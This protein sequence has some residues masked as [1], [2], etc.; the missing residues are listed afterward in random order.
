MPNVSK[1]R[2]E[3][4]LHLVQLW[5]KED[6]Y[7]QIKAAADSVQEP[8]TNWCRRALFTSLRKWEVPMAP[9]AAFEPC[10][11]CGKRHDRNEHFKAGE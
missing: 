7:Q 1:K 11:I 10:S 9:K 6:K 3:S 4:G 8:V 2:K 5:L